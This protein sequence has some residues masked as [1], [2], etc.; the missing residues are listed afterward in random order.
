MSATP[1][2]IQGTTEWFQARAG[3]ISASKMCEMMAEGDGLTREKYRTRLAI[4]RLIGKPLGGDGF[5]TKDIQRGN[6]LEPEARE[7]YEF[8]SGSTITQV[9]FIYHEELDIGMAS[10]DALVDDDGLL[11]IKCPSYAVHVKYLRT[12]KIPRA[13]LLQM[14]W[15]MA[16]TD[17]QWC[18]WLSY[19]P[20][21]PPNARALIIRCCVM[22]AKYRC[23]NVKQG[24]STRK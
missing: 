21:L 12:K 16:C 24:A 3:M 5:T 19:C 17:R 2:I 18:D 11:E 10:P 22:M 1:E 13:Y 15:Q 23:L 4:E 9:P 8:Y 20:E 14:F 7:Y 6:E